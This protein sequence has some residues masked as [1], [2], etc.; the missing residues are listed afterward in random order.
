MPAEEDAQ[1][2]VLEWE[3]RERR[4]QEEERKAETEELAVEEG[5]PPF[6]PSPSFMASTEEG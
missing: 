3:R 6:L 4:E 2:E 5:Q 1:S